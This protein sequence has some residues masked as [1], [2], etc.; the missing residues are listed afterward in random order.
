MSAEQGLCGDNKLRQTQI[1][2]R[3][4]S[5]EIASLGCGINR[6]CAIDCFQNSVRI[7]YILSC[8]NFTGFTKVFG[9]AGVLVRV[10][11]LLLPNARVSVF[12]YT[13][14]VIL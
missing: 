14:S 10:H 5:G 13:R 7:F 8:H 9:G 3:G 2:G 4:K 1:G 11:M 12:P 6:D